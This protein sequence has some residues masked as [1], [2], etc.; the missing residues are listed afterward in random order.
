MTALTPRQREVL[1]ALRSGQNTS[2]IAVSMRVN[3][4]TVREHIKAIK[5]FY[6]VESRGDRAYQEAIH[7]AAKRG[8]L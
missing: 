2:E 3:Q 6:G 1:K 5:R 7:K 4:T 8:D